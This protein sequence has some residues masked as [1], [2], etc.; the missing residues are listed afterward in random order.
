MDFKEHF[1]QTLC[2]LNIAKGSRVKVWVQDEARYGLHSIQRRFWGLKGKRVVKPG[3][4]KFDWSYVFGAL[5]ITQGDGVFCYLPGVSLGHT[6]APLGC[7]E[8]SDL[9]PRL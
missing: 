3:Q 2:D 1:Y 5:E 8:R 9:Q 6:Q 4:Q 7:H